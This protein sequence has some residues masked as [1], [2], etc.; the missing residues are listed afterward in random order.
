MGKGTEFIGDDDFRK[1]L[2]ENKRLYDSSASAKT[3]VLLAGIETQLEGEVKS[4]ERSLNTGGMSVEHILPRNMSKWKGWL[5]KNL[6]D[7]WKRIAQE[8]Y[9]NRLGNLTLVMKSFNSTY[10]N[11]TFDAKRDKTGANGEA[12]GYNRSGLHLNYEGRQDSTAPGDVG[13]W[14]AQQIEARTSYLAEHAVGILGGYPRGF[15]DAA[16]EDIRSSFERM[17]P[18]NDRNGSPR[19]FSVKVQDLLAA[20]LLEPGDKLTGIG[21]CESCTATVEMDGDLTCLGRP[22]SSPSAAAAAAR[23]S[24]GFKGITN[25]WGFWVNSRGERLYDLRKKL[26]EQQEAAQASPDAGTTTR[27]TDD[28]SRETPAAAPAP[29]DAPSPV[30]AAAAK[31][32]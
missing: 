6:G 18:S 28:P 1:A 19:R 16:E 3:K 13:E 8:Q 30:L 26:V 23:E 31:T 10:G 20:G 22:Y 24:M 5:I 15:G 7:D 29:A 2:E 32:R 27:Q 14:G 17:Y 9:L 25:G 12:I 4:R 21:M 11:E